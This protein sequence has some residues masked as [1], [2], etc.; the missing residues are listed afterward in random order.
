MPTYVHV[1][2]KMYR[3]SCNNDFNLA[4]GSPNSD[5]CSRCDNQLKQHQEM[6]GRKS[7]P[8]PEHDRERAMTGKIVLMAFDMEKTLP[9]PKLSVGE[10]FLPETIVALQFRSACNT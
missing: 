2:S 1:S 10:V 8:S 4:F 9:L 7:I 5:T 6:D 3:H